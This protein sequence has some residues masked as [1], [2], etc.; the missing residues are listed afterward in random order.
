MI[1]P[2]CGVKFAGEMSDGCAACGALQVGPPLA[3]PAHELPAYGHA[4]ASVAAGVVLVAVFIGAWVSA[5]LQFESLALDP[6]LL[7]RAAEKAA[8]RLKWT[9]LPFSLIAA[10]ACARFYRKVRRDPA[11]FAGLRHVRAGLLAS[12]AVALSII[13]LIGVTVPQRLERRELALDA[14]E[15]VVGYTSSQILSE[16]RKR[17]NSY[18]SSIADL[19]KLDDPACAFSSVIAEMELGE[20]KPVTDLASLAPQSGKGRKS[21]R[22][23]GGVRL[24][25]ASARST[26]DSPEANLSL[27]NYDLL[28]PGRDK[29]LGTDDDLLIRDGL[30]LEAS[31][32][33]DAAR[34]LASA[35]KN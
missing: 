6:Q 32:A 31:K 19:R 13:T 14:A 30:I 29:I 9:A 23:N 2:C 3:R 20:Y 16:Y 1:C 7:L 24:R 12:S 33:R 17:F 34:P 11:R 22:A 18:P 5:L 4:I 10:W 21:R 35:K 27:T 28:L 8:W 25:N 26:D 15:R